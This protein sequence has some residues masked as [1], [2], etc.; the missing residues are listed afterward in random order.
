M[1]RSLFHFVVKFLKQAVKM[2]FF[3]LLSQFFEQFSTLPHKSLLIPRTC[4]L[5]N[6]LLYSSFLESYTL[7]VFKF[8]INKLDLVSLPNLSLS[9][10]VGGFTIGHRAFPQHYSLKKLNWGFHLHVT[11]MIIMGPVFVPF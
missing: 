10:F 6:V 4:K 11:Y 2:Y 1:G 8:N 5:W 9:S 3:T 7:S